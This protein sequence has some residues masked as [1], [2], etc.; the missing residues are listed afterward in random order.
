M[1]EKYKKFEN[2]LDKL[3]EEGEQ[4]HLAMQNDCHGEAFREHGKNQLG[5]KKFEDL[6]KNCLI[7]MIN[8]KVG[9]RRHR[10]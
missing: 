10:H 8:I 9:T 2:A 7:L 4:L 3:I 6:I 1:S 5:E